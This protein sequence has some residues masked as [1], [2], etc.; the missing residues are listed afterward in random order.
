MNTNVYVIVIVISK[1]NDT[2]K[3][4]RTKICRH[5]SHKSILVPNIRYNSLHVML[6]IKDGLT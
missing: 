2:Y 4:K 1:Y 5:K 6:L 3:T